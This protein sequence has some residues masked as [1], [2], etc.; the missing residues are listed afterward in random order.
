[1][2]LYIENPKDSKGFP[3]VSDGKESTYNVENPGS[4]P[5]STKSPGE[6][7]GYPLRYSC[8]ENFMDRG[9]CELQSLGSQRVRHDWVTNMYTRTPQKLLGL[10]NEF[11]QVAGYK[12]NI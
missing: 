8:L 10:I 3:C 2:L 7:N 1:M 4:I 6:G 12:I 11:S 9:A 5:G